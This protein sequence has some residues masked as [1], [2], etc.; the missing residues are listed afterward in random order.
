MDPV[1]EDHA[2]ERM[3]I[4]YFETGLR[5]QIQDAVAGVVNR[6]CDML[7]GGEAGA[8]T[9]WH[10]AEAPMN[11]VSEDHVP[12]RTKRAYSDIGLRE[13]IEDAVM[14]RINRQCDRGQEEESGV[15][16]LH[17]CETCGKAFSW[18][19]RL[20]AHIRTHTAE[21]NCVCEI[22]GVAFAA[23]GQLVAHMWTH[24][25][26]TNHQP[27]CSCVC[28]W[29]CRPYRSALIEH[30]ISLVNGA[31]ELVFSTKHPARVQ[32]L[33]LHTAADNRV[34]ASSDVNFSNNMAYTNVCAVG[35]DHV[36]GIQRLALRAACRLQSNLTPD[37]IAQ[38]LGSCN[39]TDVHNGRLLQLIASTDIATDI[40]YVFRSNDKSPKFRDDDDS[41]AKLRLRLE[42]IT[43]KT[44]TSTVDSIRVLQ[45][46]QFSNSLV[47]ADK[48]AT[49]SSR[50]ERPRWQDGH[51]VAAR[52]DHLMRQK[53][54]SARGVATLSLY[55]APIHGMDHLN[56][57]V[58]FSPV[59]VPKMIFKVPKTV[60]GPSAY[61]KVLNWI[62]TGDLPNRDAVTSQIPRQFMYAFNTSSKEMRV[63]HRHTGAEKTE[64]TFAIFVKED[65]TLRDNAKVFVP[66]GVPKGSLVTEL[67]NCCEAHSSVYTRALAHLVLLDSMYR[68]GTISTKTSWNESSQRWLNTYRV[69]FLSSLAWRGAATGVSADK[70]YIDYCIFSQCLKQ[71]I[72]GTRMPC[73]SFSLL[74]Q[75]G[76]PFPYV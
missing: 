36:F 53:M 28:D 8:A 46:I 63:F 38:R 2:S 47:F 57:C 6:E 12:G 50:A 29:G 73:D 18:N 31:Y 37:M 4:P 41:M 74:V 27:S 35:V 14:D 54:M 42:K 43:M 15:K 60:S 64:H 69:H 34:I 51:T 67:L 62:A 17:V 45:D 72:N 9:R 75:Q 56:A 39:R 19:D 11:S 5:E 33:L 71:H 16:R 23:A 10:V 3:D 49:S 48:R 65:S 7:Q 26:G 20:V 66:Q 70:Q 52:S 40:G 13:E 59:N 30:K 22:C 1:S 55:T 61:S 76:I 25:G 21:S 68:L 44:E 58:V 24:T 32:C